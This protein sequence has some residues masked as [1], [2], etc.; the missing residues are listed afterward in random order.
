VVTAAANDAGRGFGC[1]Q[2]KAPSV[3]QRG[4]RSSVLR[5]LDP[6]SLPLPAAPLLFLLHFPLTPLDTL[7]PAPLFFFL[8]FAP[9]PPVAF[10]SSSQLVHAE[11]TPWLSSQ[12]SSQLVGDGACTPLAGMQM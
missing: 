5:S 9:L 11:G 4:Q 7:A 2:S 1:Q 10:T 3:E 8:L 6:H 12:D